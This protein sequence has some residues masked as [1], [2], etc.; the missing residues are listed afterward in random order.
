MASRTL[1]AFKHFEL[2]HFNLPL[3]P[4]WPTLKL[5]L[6]SHLSNNG[7]RVCLSE[8]HM[9]TKYVINCDNLVLT[10]SSTYMHI[11]PSTYHMCT[12]LI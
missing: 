5:S 4:H 1:K 3:A 12:N 11:R 2:E 8:R 7:R 6:E 10:Y 9:A